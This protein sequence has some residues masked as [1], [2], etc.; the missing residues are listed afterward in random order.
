MLE[1]SDSQE[2]YD[3]TKL[4]FELSH[5]WQIPFIIRTTTRVAHS[6]T[7]VEYDE[8]SAKPR[9][10]A[11][12]NRDISVRV[13]VPGHAKPAHKRLRQKFADMLKWNDEQGPNQIIDGK[14]KKLG[15]I[16]S[17]IAFMHAFEAAP[18]AGFFK[19]GFSNPLPVNRIKEFAAQY[20]RCVVIE[21]GDPYMDDSSARRRRERR[22]A[23]GK[24]ALRRTHRRQGKGADRRRPIL[25]DTRN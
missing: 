2:A 13:M 6:N 3:F 4:A 20:D 5:R 10:K 19:V 15:I 1:P 8:Q 24:M 14:D 16:S 12:F 22:A 11:N 17:G 7:I 23:R 18:E 9:P 21:E 25:R